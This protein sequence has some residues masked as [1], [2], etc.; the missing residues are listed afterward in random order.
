[1]VSP[2]AIPLLVSERMGLPSL[3]AVL[4]TAFRRMSPFQS[5]SPVS[6]G[7]FLAASLDMLFR[8]KGG[9][10]QLEEAIETLCRRAS[11]AVKS[12]YT[13]LI[14]SDRGVD[15]Q[16]APIPSLLPTPGFVF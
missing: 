1:M 9:E 3:R 16:Y 7:D 2:T 5:Q 8:A 13:L 11:L 10:E 12:G 4:T 14:L 6:H 15:E